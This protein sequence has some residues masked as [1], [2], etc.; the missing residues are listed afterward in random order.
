VIK[1]IEKIVPYITEKITE[2]E[3]IREKPVLTPQIEERIK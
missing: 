1:E 2:V 3:V